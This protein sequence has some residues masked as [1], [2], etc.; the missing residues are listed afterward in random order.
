[1]KSEVVGVD[2]ARSIRFDTVVLS[3]PD[4]SLKATFSFGKRECPHAKP[5]SGRAA[6]ER[7][8][9]PQSSG[10]GTRNQRRKVASASPSDEFG[11]YV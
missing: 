2:S 6:N 9:T 8:G 3:Q 4:K 1:M 7:L 5:K 10:V 11:S